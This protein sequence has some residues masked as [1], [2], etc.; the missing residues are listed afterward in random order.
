MTVSGLGWNFS[1]LVL[2]DYAFGHS[3]EGNLGAGGQGWKIQ[4]AG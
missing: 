2:L 1:Y 4:G 3:S